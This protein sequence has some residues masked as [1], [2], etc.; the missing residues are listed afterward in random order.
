[1]KRRREKRKKEEEDKKNNLDRRTDQRIKN[2]PNNFNDLTFG[3]KT[4]IIRFCS[5]LRKKKG[6]KIGGLFR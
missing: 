1:M 5:L 6:K 4:N 2:L 3:V